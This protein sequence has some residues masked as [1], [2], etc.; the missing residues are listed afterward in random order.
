MDWI[1]EIRNKDGDHLA[2]HIAHQI[3]HSMQV[4]WIT[5]HI[6]LQVTQH[7]RIGNALPSKSNSCHQNPE[8]PSL[9][10]ILLI[11]HQVNARWF[12]NT[13][14]WWGWGTNA[15]PSAKPTFC[16]HKKKLPGS[17]S[18]NQICMSVCHRWKNRIPVYRLLNHC[19]LWKDLWY[20]SYFQW[21]HAQLWHLNGVG[22]EREK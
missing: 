12:I 8:I 20:H 1:S 13:F 3:S 18:L 16:K 7:S 15:N 22:G 11:L 2:N 10:P 5:I 6:T 19:S 21:H 4:D 17:Y 14:K 9:T